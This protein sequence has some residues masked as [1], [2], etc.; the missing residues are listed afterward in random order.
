ME[1][2]NRAAAGCFILGIFYIGFLV[3]AVAK[4]LNKI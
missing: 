1:K 4:I 2:D 3:W